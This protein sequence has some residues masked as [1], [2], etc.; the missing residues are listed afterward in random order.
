MTSPLLLAL[1]CVLTIAGS[2]LAQLECPADAS[3]VLIL[4]GGLTG[5]AAAKRLSD[6]GQNN[7]ILLEAQDRLGGRMRN[8]EVAAGINVNVGANWIHG[9]DQSDPTRHPLFALLQ[10]CGGLAGYYSNFGSI[11]TYDENG[12]VL[13]QSSLRQSVYTTASDAL[14]SNAVNDSARIALTN[15]GWTPNGANDNW[16]EW[17]NFDFSNID[18]PDTTSLQGFLNDATN[19][20]FLAS[21]SNSASDYLITDNRG[22]VYLVECLANSFTNNNLSSDS[23]IHLNA[24]VSRIEHGDNCVCAMATE[25]GQ[26]VRYC[27]RYGIVT[28]SLGVLKAQAATLFSPTLPA[29]KINALNGINLGFYYIIYATFDNRFWDDDREFIGVIS[30]ERGYL[31]IIGV[32]SESKGVNA[33]MMPVTGEVA[34]ELA[35]LSEADLRTAITTLYSDIYGNAASAPT[36]I[37]SFRW[38]LNPLFQGSYSNILPGGVAGLTEMA[39]PEGSMYLAGEGSSAKYN[40]FMHGSYLSGIATVNTIMGLSSGVKITGNALLVVLV[41]IINIRY[42]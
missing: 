36:N 18:P 40:G 24:M 29:T 1:V 15:E 25:N 35:R 16:V 34:F 42:F 8:E 9:V 17:F 3:E 10:E 33:T 26:T 21:P 12:N 5:A 37:V 27:G 32:V 13:P 14:P 7:F 39:K 23:R 4:G 2:A 11:R 20:D 30:S 28:F 22:T 38:G 31:P 19:N 6:L 41:A